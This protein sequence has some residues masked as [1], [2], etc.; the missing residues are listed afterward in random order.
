MTVKGNNSI[1]DRDHSELCDDLDLLLVLG[2]KVASPQEKGRITQHVAGCSWCAR[3]GRGSSLIGACF[4][5][6]AE[7]ELRAKL[8]TVFGHIDWTS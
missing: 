4:S 6:Q 1:F 8:E 7:Q 2:G 3:S 5:S